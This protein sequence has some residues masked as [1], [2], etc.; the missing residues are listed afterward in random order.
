MFVCLQ[1]WD[2]AKNH[3]IFKDTTYD[4]TYVFS[5][6][7]QTRCLQILKMESEK[8]QAVGGKHTE[9]FLGNHQSASFDE[10]P[11]ASPTTPFLVQKFSFA[12]CTVRS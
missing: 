4:N 12:L 10:A 8:K 3:W 1:F 6:F 2:W 9:R 11:V 5:T 7:K